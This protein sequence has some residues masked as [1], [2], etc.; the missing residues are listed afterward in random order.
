MSDLAQWIS[1]TLLA[2][3][4][5]NSLKQERGFTR[6]GFSPEEK[7]AHEQFQKIATRLGMKTWQDEVGNQWA[8]WEVDHA[9]PTI[10]LGSHLDTVVEGGAYDG[11]AG[12]VC[13]LGAVRLLKEKNIKPQKNIAIICFICEESARF[14]ISTI[15]SKT[16]VGDIDKEKWEKI[17]DSDGITLRQAM[18]EY[19]INWHT[20][21][22]AFC[23]NHRLESF[24]ELHIEQGNQLY[25]QKKDIGIV[26]G[27]ATPIRLHVTANGHANH[28]GTTAMDDRKDALV[29][30]APLINI[31]EQ[32]AR[33]VNRQ[34]RHDLVATVTTVQIE[35][36]VM[37]V[38]PGT[39]RLGI[40]IR[41]VDDVLKRKFAKFIS[42]E[43][44]RLAKENELQIEVDVL[45]DEPSV[46]LDQNI[47]EKLITICDELGVSY[48]VMNSGAGHDVMNMAKRW[49]AGLI[50]LP[51]VDGISHHPD[52]YTPLKSLEIGV[53]VLAAY[54]EREIG[55]NVS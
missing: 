18:E 26:H 27:I 54:I 25:K 10:G 39:V 14:G 32:K 1:Q 45:V 22:A 47:Q 42:A 50:F 6:L 20:F 28:S 41:S 37:N 36:N 13:A 55:G 23:D 53:E 38:I 11:V 29:A 43:C 24:L 52:E 33:E 3:N 5:T 12:I 31:I 17:T 4:L 7:R 9:A 48:C 46:I 19:G 8:L 30:I 40:D 51:S 15:G 34:S 21:P 35:P 16:I 49:P 44:R 2:L